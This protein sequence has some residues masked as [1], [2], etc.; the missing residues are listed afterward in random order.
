[1]VVANDKARKPVEVWMLFA[2]ICQLLHG[3]RSCASASYPPCSQRRSTANSEIQIEMDSFHMALKLKWT[4]E[5]FVMLASPPCLAS[6]I[7]LSRT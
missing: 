1:M 7:A 5:R 3:G 2:Q 6:A 4:L